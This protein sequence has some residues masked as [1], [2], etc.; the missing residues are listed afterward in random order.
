MEPDLS[1]MED[2]IEQLGR[3]IERLQEQRALACRERNRHIPMARLP[4]EIMM[5]IF[6]WGFVSSYKEEKATEPTTFPLRLGKVC[7]DWRHIA[8]RMP[9]LW[10]FFHLRISRRRS[11]CQ[12]DLLS[13]WLDRSQPRLLSLNLSVEDEDS[14]TKSPDVPTGIIDTL[15]AHSVRWRRLSLVLPECWYGRIA[16]VRGKIQNLKSLAIRPPGCVFINKPVDAFADA[17]SLKSLHVSHTY[18]SDLRFPWLQLTSVALGTASTDEALELIRRCPNLATCH[19][20]DLNELEANFPADIVMHSRLEFLEVSLHPSAILEDF[21]IYLVL[22]DLRRLTL[23]LPEGH[24]PPIPVIEA[25]L[26]RSPC[27]L[28]E[29][30]IIGPYISEHDIITFLTY[31]NSVTDLTAKPT[32]PPD[33]NIQEEIQGPST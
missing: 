26:E 4:V 2:Q 24:P 10:S 3:A 9:G 23:T 21:L 15:I 25:F 22:S 17:P 31:N 6:M 33:R 18:L 13:E 1:E 20:Q 29:L 28:K 27:P 14:W 12:A 30:T 32:T 19:F 5:E 16:E 8:W 11:T 7:Y